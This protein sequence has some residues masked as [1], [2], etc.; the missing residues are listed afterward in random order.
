MLTHQGDLSGNGKR[1]AIRDAEEDKVEDKWQEA[2]RLVQSGKAGAIVSVKNAHSTKKRPSSKEDGD[3]DDDRDGAKQ[4]KKKHRSADSS[5]KKKTG[6][7]QKV[8]K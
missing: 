3:A 6:K 8:H 5:S 1:Y 7:S 2:E 4:K